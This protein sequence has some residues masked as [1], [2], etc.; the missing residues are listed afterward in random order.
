MMQK[1]TAI[2]ALAT[3][4]AFGGLAG[5]DQKNASTP[6]I[7]VVDIGKVLK[8]SAIG[9]QE[10]E[11]GKQV[12]AV[13]IKANDEAKQGYA[14]LSADEQKKAS[15]AD[16][17]VLN[18]QWMA[19]QKAARQASLA[20]IVK[21]VDTYRQEKK[22]ALIVDNQNVISSDAKLDVTADIITRLEKTQVTYGDLPTI[23]V[24]KPEAAES[25]TPAEHAPNENK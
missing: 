10:I 9:K 21:A 8:D 15:N 7:G 13:L 1:K 19:E 20:A 11:H 16:A 2:L 5:C 17:Q 18:H 25:E 23:T 24:K 14:A 3:T 6:E 4:L 22:L 12:Q